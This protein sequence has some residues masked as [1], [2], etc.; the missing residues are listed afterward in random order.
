MS[1]KL[2]VTVL[3]SGSGESWS[4]QHLRRFGRLTHR[5]LISFV[6]LLP[7][8][9]FQA[10][11]DALPTTLSTVSITS[12]IS[13][14]TDAYGLTRARTHSQPCPIPAEAFPLL[15]WKKQPE[16][17]GKDRQAWELDLATKI[18]E[19]R[20]D[21]VVLAGWMLILSESFLN[22]LVHDWDEGSTPLPTQSKVPV[23]D[24]TSSVLPSIETNGSSPYP[25]S[26]DLC[27]KPIPIINL[28]PALPGQFPGA[29]A[30]KDA[31]EAFQVPDDSTF[32]TSSHQDAKEVLGQLAA[33]GGDE[34]SKQEKEEALPNK[35]RITKTGLMI[36]RVIP[37]LDAGEPVVVREVEMIEGESLEGLEERIHKVEHEAIVEAV[38]VC[39]KLI[40]SG[41][42]WDK[43]D[44]GRD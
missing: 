2:R 21:L 44:V 5:F 32:I 10:L 19:T 36:H 29:H 27:R 4:D 13:S 7:G 18:K 34:R 14:R 30:I 26:F 35:R 12:V 43:K 41:E 25:A 1:R 11:L 6:I 37:L 33:E 3:I 20:P 42:W 15:K 17:S 16:N 9:N 31:W 23:L 8:S 24:P 28:H 39:E 38:G 40:R 22:A